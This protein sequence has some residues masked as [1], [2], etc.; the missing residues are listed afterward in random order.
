MAN[1]EREQYQ[2]A[3]LELIGSRPVAY[4]PSLARLLGGVK[5]AVLFSQLLYWHGDKTVK[6]REGWF[7]KSVEE[8]EEETGLTKLEQ[9]S[10]RKALLKIGV[11]DCKL[12]GVPRVWNY[13]ILFDNFT[14]ILIDRQT[15]PMDN[16]PDE[17]PT[18]HW[19]GLRSN[20]GRFQRPMMGGFDGQHNKNQ[21]LPETTKKTTTK[22]TSSPVYPLLETETYPYLTDLTEEEEEG[23]DKLKGLLG[24]IAIF[25]KSLPEVISL[26]LQKNLS[27]ADV[28]KMIAGAKKAEPDAPAGLFLFRLRKRIGK[29]A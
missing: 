4:W 13:Q 19:A 25:E 18:Q 29:A 12:T 6:A 21:R 22:T 1:P 11:I 10:A 5:P 16:P 17:K 23:F 24:D 9:Q 7:Y 15:H 28:E 20:D 26:I 2:R 3:L 14:S 27:Q 8:L